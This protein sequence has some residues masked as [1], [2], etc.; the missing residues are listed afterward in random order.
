M[1]I[2]VTSFFMQYRNSINRALD[3]IDFNI[4]T[5]IGNIILE[6]IKNN[7]TILVCGNGG[8][9]AIAEHFTCDHSKGVQSNTRFYPKYISLTSNVSL[10]TAYANDYGYDQV[11]SSQVKHHG[12]QGDILICISSSGSSPNII[13][14]IEAGNDK[15]MHTISF[16]GFTGGKAKTLSKHN[17]HI[18]SN[19]YGVVEDCH[20]IVMHNLAQFIRTNNSTVDLKD[21]RL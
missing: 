6:G 10:L 5:D 7:K 11:F 19:N 9:A 3:S 15:G 14:A 4:L 21:V 20:Q 12:S 2:S 1:L 8:S 13:N 17:L 16:T 18:N